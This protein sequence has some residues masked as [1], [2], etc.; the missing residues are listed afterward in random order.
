MSLLQSG[1]PIESKIV[2]EAINC[3]SKDKEPSLYTLALV[4]YAYAAAGKTDLAQESLKKLMGD[5][6]EKS[7]IRWVPID[8]KKKKQG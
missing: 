7:G 1:V 3:L 2:N 5:M 4:S 6:K 8:G